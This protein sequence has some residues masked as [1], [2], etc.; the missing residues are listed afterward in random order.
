[1]LK[2]D[3]E[4]YPTED[5][6][7]ENILIHSI[8][9]KKKKTFV[10]PF[11]YDPTCDSAL[12]ETKPDATVPGSAAQEEEAPG[13]ATYERLLAD[14][15]RMK[16]VSGGDAGCLYKKPTICPQVFFIRASYVTKTN[17]QMPHPEVKYLAKGLKQFYITTGI[18]IAYMNDF[19]VQIYNIQ[20]PSP[21]T[22]V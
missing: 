6:T 7:L 10:D 14:G 21:E 3:I 8:P 5:L 9:A 17:A 1:M 11:P 13:T 19:S 22:V 12:D 15:G 2:N 16:D 20:K 18:G 4:K